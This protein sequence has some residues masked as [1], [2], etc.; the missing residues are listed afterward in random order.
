MAY[1]RVPLDT[2]VDEFS[3]TTELS[4]VALGGRVLSVS[5]EF[6]AEAGQLLLVERSAREQP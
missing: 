2:F 1:R 5:D 6:F 4:S 3:A